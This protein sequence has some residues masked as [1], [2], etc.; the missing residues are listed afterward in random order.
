MKALIKVLKDHLSFWSNPKKN[1]K[2]MLI[3][4]IG[5]VLVF[6]ILREIF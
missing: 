3:E 4:V 2:W 5:T 1:W 6:F